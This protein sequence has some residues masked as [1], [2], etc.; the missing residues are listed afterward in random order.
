[1]KAIERAIPVLIATILWVGLWPGTAVADHIGELQHRDILVGT[2]TEAVEKARIG[3]HYTGWLE[4]NSEFESSRSLE[5]PLYFV[6]G[7]GE[8][9]QGWEEGVKGMREGG[10]REL[11]IP[12]D[13]AYG[14]K[15]SATIPANSTLRFEV[16]LI[17]VET[18][19]Y[20]EIGN[21]ELRRMLEDG[22]RIIDI[23]TPRQWA[24]T[25][26]IRGSVRLTAFDEYGTLLSTFLPRLRAL[27][28][29]D[30]ELI[31]LGQIGAS[32]KSLAE[33]LAEGAG[34]SHLYNVTE[35]I[36]VWIAKGYPVS[37]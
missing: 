21:V 12:P 8:V 14:S 4:D 33:M 24:V 29:P 7:A 31:L 32:S 6:I 10:K 36:E 35:G 20:I 22:V 26:T 16:E 3:V 2:G 9:I 28:G 37:R 18:P 1:M 11:I 15:G 27:A 23:R 13:M 17:S 5:S 19:A 30:E 34:Y 25:G